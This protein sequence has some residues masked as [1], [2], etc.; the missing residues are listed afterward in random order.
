MSTLAITGATGQLGRLVIQQLLQQSAANT[1]VACVR[2]PEKAADLTARGVQVRRADYNDP[3]SLDHAFANV[4]RLLLISSSEVGQRAAQHR[5]AIE[6]AKRQKVRLVVYTSLLHADTS[7]LNLGDEHRQTEAMLKASGLPFI[8]LRNGWYFEN[9]TAS[10]PA[11]L[12]LGAFYGSA[13]EGRISAASRADYAA[14]AAR[15]LTGAVPPGQVLELAGDS[16]FTLSELAAELSRQSG[17]SIPYRNLPEADYRG[18]LLKAGLPDWLAAG[19][20]SWDVG[21]S[22]GAL[23]DG[24]KTL[25]RL[26]ER[27][28][29]PLSEAVKSA[30][31]PR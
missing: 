16:A 11:A 18:A 27:P 7:V 15:A 23:F 29:T 26:L 22:Q 12:S 14:A 9:Y 3:A 8:I 19:L 25:G 31:A 13:G 20:A 28:T 10:I 17:K 24:S 4:E 21:A 30:L 1:I 6:A 5:N 2:S